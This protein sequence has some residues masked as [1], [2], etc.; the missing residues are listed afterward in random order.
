MA[1]NAIIFDVDGTLYDAPSLRRAIS[2]RLIS[3]L[4]NQPLTA[5]RTVRLLRNFR[6]AQEQMRKERKACPDLWLTQIEYAM[7]RSGG[8]SEWASA[9][10][11]RWMQEEPLPLLQRC[12]R[13]GI[14]S[15]LQHCADRSIRMAALSDYPAEAKLVAMNLRHFFSVVLCAQDKDIQRFKPDPL[16]L[17]R[18]IERLGVSPES[19]IYVGDRRD[20]DFVAAQA[21]GLR[22]VLLPKRFWKCEITDLEELQRVIAQA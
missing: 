19:A 8:T 10:I 17:S 14:V 7:R 13:P 11:Q 1:L 12:V 22:C 2:G 9:V 4:W 21:V 15:L 16:G 6:A 20:V 3:S 18:T 5:I